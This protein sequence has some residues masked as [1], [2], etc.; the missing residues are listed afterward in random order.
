MVSGQQKQALVFDCQG[1]R[2]VGILTRPQDP[3]VSVTTALIALPAGGPQYRVGL[4]RQLLQQASYL[5]ER[6]IAVLR[7]DYRGIGD[8]EGEFQGFRSVEPDL[9]AAIDEL[10]LQ[11]P[12]LKNVILWGG[13]NAASAIMILAQKLPEVNGIVVSNPFLG[14]HNLGQQAKLLHFYSRIKQKSFWSKLLSGKYD[15]APYLKGFIRS[16]KKQPGIQ[17]KQSENSNSP[18]P[19][20][21]KPVKIIDDMFNGMTKYSG[22]CLFLLSDRSIQSNEFRALLKSSKP[23]RKLFKRPKTKIVNV[24]NTDQNFSSLNSQQQLRQLTYEWIAS[25]GLL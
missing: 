23:W 2:L 12:E 22:H 14:D 4:A 5:C 10:K 8:S 13:C 15:L 1:E 21:N 3:A 24:E 25:S 17:T 16:F 9:R 7:F 18:K 11:L 20:T 6:N 19:A